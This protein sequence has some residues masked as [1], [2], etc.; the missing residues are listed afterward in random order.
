MAQDVSEPVLELMPHCEEVDVLR[1]TTFD[2]ATPTSLTTPPV[3]PGS[4]V[5]MDIVLTNPHAE[6]IRSF[7]AWISFDPTMLIG[8]DVSVD[9]AVFAVSDPANT[10]IDQETGVI[11]M[12]ASATE[13]K[14][15]R[16]PLIRLGRIRM[17]VP[18]GTQAGQTPMAFTDLLSTTAGHTYVTT[19]ASNTENLI[20]QQ[21]G[22]LLVDIRQSETE[23]SSSSSVASAAS[24][25]PVVI[26]NTSGSTSSSSSTSVAPSSAPGT[27]A[28][29]DLLQV[30]NVQVGTRDDTVSIAWA[31]L[32]HSKVQA[33]NV[34]YGI[35]PG[36]YLHRRSVSVVSRGLVIDNLMPGK[37]YYLAV[38]AADGSG[39][40][41]AY[42][43]EVSI[44][45]GNAK[46]ATAPLTDVV[47]AI[48]TSTLTAAIDRAPETPI[49]V[50]Q[51]LESL[52]GSTGPASALTL[53]LRLRLIH[54]R[55]R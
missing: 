27:S 3:A 49:S 4:V 47:A 15:P 48:D 32:D 9:S 40:E 38:R 8:K 23:P 37:T 51:N 53:F 16:S 36:Q 14:E 10:D 33:Y 43:K 35:T 28:V 52:P 7:S 54:H 5:D 41:T 11:K 31:P 1:C 39:N 55:W 46:S 30:Q 17:L 22:S 21:L 34:Y 18:E 24:S 25:A 6:M 45:V 12:A 13:G 29:F 50:D 44:E 42:S 19:S 2:A 26:I 20:T